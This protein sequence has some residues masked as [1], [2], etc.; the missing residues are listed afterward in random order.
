MTLVAAVWIGCSSDPVTQQDPQNKPLSSP[1]T[2]VCSVGMVTDIVSQVVGGQGNVIGLMGEG[3]DPH[4]YK[5]TRDD[6][7]QL[8]KADLVYYVGLMLEGRMADTFMKISRS[9]V[10]VYP[11]TESIEESYLL[12]PAGF[13]G[14]WDP[15]VWMDVAAWSQCVEVIEHSLCELD[16]AN[17]ES[18]RQNSKAYRARL[19]ELHQYVKT[20]IATI[21]EEQRSLVTAHD[22]FGYFSR[23][24]DIR[25][26]AAQGI[27]TESEA[28]VADI[29]QLVD[30][31]VTHQ[32]P[33]LFVES[34]VADKN[35]RAVLEGAA[36]KGHTVRIGGELF[37]D[38][39]GQPGTYE[40]TYIGMIDHN[41]TTIARALGGQA[42]AGGFQGKL[43]SHDKPATDK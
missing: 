11:V 1:Y 31:M 18:Y 43:N 36:S 22:A 25:V 32:I 20:V 37:S 38:A 34:T 13:N 40:G 39:M 14:H 5:P 21:P 35:L 23:A 24:Y 33:A 19:S 10:P 6:V 16:P 26:R 15:H 12:E 2:V 30:Y 7:S 17:A 28:G 9:G 41:A 42:P 29:N 3:V 4:M 8:L 27:S